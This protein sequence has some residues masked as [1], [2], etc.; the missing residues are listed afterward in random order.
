MFW[1]QISAS[2]Q[3]RLGEYVL[4]LQRL[5]GDSVVHMLTRPQRLNYQFNRDDVEKLDYDDIN[6]RGDYRRRDEVVFL[7]KEAKTTGKVSM[8]ARKLTRMPS[9][10]RNC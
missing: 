2:W 7:A 10:R 1:V 9:H 4:K 3:G 5:C 6:V 8:S